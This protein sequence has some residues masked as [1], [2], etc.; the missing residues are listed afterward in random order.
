[1]N[2]V[3]RRLLIDFDDEDYR[4]N[5][6]TRYKIELENIDP[7]YGG[8]YEANIKNLSLSNF[9]IWENSNGCLMYK[10]SRRIKWI[11]TNVPEDIQKDEGYYKSFQCF[12][13][14]ENIK[15]DWWSDMNEW[16]SAPWIVT[17][18]D[19]LNL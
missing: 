16:K 11:L 17:K 12:L 10:D 6:I 14:G 8:I 2:S 1:M 13:H 3:C 15:W 18:I 9:P 4:Q 5:V 19:F 7:L